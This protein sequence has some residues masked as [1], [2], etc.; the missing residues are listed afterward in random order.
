MENQEELHRESKYI[1]PILEKLIVSNKFEC[2]GHALKSIS[3]LITFTKSVNKDLEQPKKTRIYFQQGIGMKLLGII[4][5]LYI[6]TELSEG[7]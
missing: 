4:S 7:D 6:E 1:L 2:R 3:T 5:N